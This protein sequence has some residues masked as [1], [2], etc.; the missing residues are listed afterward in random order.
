M[1][2]RFFLGNTA[3]GSWRVGAASLYDMRDWQ[4]ELHGGELHC[5]PTLATLARR[6]WWTLAGILVLAL[7]FLSFGLPGSG[8]D[9][10]DAR[11]QQRAKRRKV[12]GRNLED[13]LRGALSPEQAR[14]AERQRAERQREREQDQ[15]QAERRSRGFRVVGSVLYWLCL[16]GGLV[17]AV[18]PPAVI[19]LQYVTITTSPENEL[20]VNSRIFLKRERRW[21]IDSLKSLE[22]AACEQIQR[23]RRRLMIRDGWN[24]VVR[25]NTSPF[26]GTLPLSAEVGQSVI[27]FCVDH[28]KETPHDVNKPPRRVRTFAEV[29]EQLLGLNVSKYRLEEATRHRPRSFWGR[30]LPRVKRTVS[31][32]IES[33]PT[34]MRRKFRSLDEVPPELRSRIESMM[35]ESEAQGGKPI[36]HESVRVTI[37]DSDG[38]ERTYHSLEEMPP[39]VRARYE[40]MRRARQGDVR[41]R[42][43]RG[44]I[45]DSE[46]S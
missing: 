5:R 29:F 13:V 46:E 30:K 15:A 2:F 41:E 35:R 39:D 1:Q 3:D 11:D 40:K 25:L 6:L 18:L 26:G 7:L 32:E 19:P 24:W 38:N 43:D 21:P 12:E 33:E 10:A 22:I 17:L 27:E 9:A 14:V 8:S 20:V 23:V 28:Q 31:S 4:I 44:D 16:M 34:V 42:S 36:T 45:E 37:R